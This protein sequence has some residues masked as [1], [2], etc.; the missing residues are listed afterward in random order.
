LE[1]QAASIDKR[2]EEVK[3]TTTEASIVKK[4]RRMATTLAIRMKVPLPSILLAIGS[5][6]CIAGMHQKEHH[7]I[8]SKVECD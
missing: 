5:V 1:Q 2:V 3:S 7:C 8:D 4:T 6:G